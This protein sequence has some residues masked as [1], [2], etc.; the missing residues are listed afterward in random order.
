[1]ALALAREL[2]SY[3]LAPGG[4]GLE[5]LRTGGSGIRERTAVARSLIAFA[6]RLDVIFVSTLCLVL[7]VLLGLLRACLP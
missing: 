2:S 3:R 1:M 6:F 4:C 7:L 5:A